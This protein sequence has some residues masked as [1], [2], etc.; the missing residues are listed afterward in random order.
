VAVVLLSGIDLDEIRSQ[1]IEGGREREREERSLLQRRLM[2]GGP[3]PTIEW[4]AVV[5]VGRA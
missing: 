2:H 1:V 4:T 3:V 5:L